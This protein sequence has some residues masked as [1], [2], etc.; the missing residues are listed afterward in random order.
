MEELLEKLEKYK[1]LLALEYAE[2]H[3]EE[4][5]FLSIEEIKPLVGITTFEIFLVISDY[6]KDY[7]DKHDYNVDIVSLMD[8]IL[9]LHLVSEE[10]E[11]VS[12]VENIVSFDLRKKIHSAKEEMEENDARIMDRNTWGEEKVDLRH[13]NTILANTIDKYNAIIVSFEEYVNANKRPKR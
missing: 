12:F 1:E 3:P 5:E 13:D 2:M 10:E 4:T 7:L 9:A 11:L 8:E 6:V